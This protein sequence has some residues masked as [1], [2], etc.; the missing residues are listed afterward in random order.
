MNNIYPTDLS[1]LIAEM[2][3]GKFKHLQ[4]FLSRNQSSLALGL[5]QQYLIATHDSFGV[6]RLSSV[7]YSSGNI[8][9]SLTDSITGEHFG[10][11]LDVNKEHPDYIF[12]WWND[13]KKMINDESTSRSAVE[14]VQELDNE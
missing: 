13:I 4:I 6:Y 1:E 7:D 5:G 10:I 3:E 12:I 8:H 9:I 2:Q 14:Q 11:C